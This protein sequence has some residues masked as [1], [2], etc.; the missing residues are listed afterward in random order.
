M[1]Y[2]IVFMSHHGTTKKVVGLLAEKLGTADTVIVD[3]DQNDPPPL[4]G[5]ILYSV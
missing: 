3:L 2:L 4:A 1:K 5:M